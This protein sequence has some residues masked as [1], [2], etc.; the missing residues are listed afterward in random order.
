[1]LTNVLNVSFGGFG[2]VSSRS[3]VANELYE[4]E[5]D[6]PDLLDLQSG[7]EAEAE[8]RREDRRGRHDEGFFWGFFPV[9]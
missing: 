4:V 1:M 2:W 7:P 5:H 6:S 3:R 8:P 9:L